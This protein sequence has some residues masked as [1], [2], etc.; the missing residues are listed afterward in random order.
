[1]YLN[2]LGVAY[3]RLGRFDEAADALR[4]SLEQTDH[5]A[6]DLFFLA[7]TFQKLSQP[8]KARDY[9]TQAEYWLSINEES[10]ESSIREELEA[11]RSEANALGLR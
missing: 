7:M 11:F 4:R 2:T 6:H 8:D 5:P 9:Y 10:L 3:Y 1:M